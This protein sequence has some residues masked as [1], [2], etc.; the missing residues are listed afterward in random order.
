MA[1]GQPDDGRPP[2]SVGPR[3]DGEG[4]GETV[5]V[6]RPT[7][8]GTAVQTKYIDRA[9]VMAYDITPPVQ[10]G[11]VPVASSYMVAELK[12]DAGITFDQDGL[13]IRTCGNH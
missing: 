8:S 2:Q 7:G 12:K 3:T 5:D 9:D 13:M 10:G 1:G 11:P 6:R 4:T